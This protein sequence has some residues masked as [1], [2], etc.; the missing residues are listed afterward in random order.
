M[1]PDTRTFSGVA[2]LSF[3]QAWCSDGVHTQLNI[4]A[5]VNVDGFASFV[6]LTAVLN[7]NQAFQN[8][9]LYRLQIAINVEGLSTSN[10]RI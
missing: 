6:V 10:F 7:E 5:Y 9:M 1:L 4:G 3:L 2:R 8:V